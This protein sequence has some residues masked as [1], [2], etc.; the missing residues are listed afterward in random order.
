MSFETDAF[1]SEVEKRPPLYN[2]KMKEYSDKMLKKKLWLEIFEKFVQNWPELGTAE[3][4]AK[5]T[6]LL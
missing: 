2:V 5:G 4:E 6:L 1:I 3:K